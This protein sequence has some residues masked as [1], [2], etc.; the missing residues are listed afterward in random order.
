M[1]ANPH[2]VVITT[3]LKMIV[4]VERANHA[5]KRFNQRAFKIGFAVVC[6]Q[7]ILFH[8]LVGNNHMRG[9]AAHPREGVAGAVRAVREFQV[10]LNHIT[11]TRLEFVLP[12]FTHGQNIAAK[13]VADDDWVGRHIVGYFFMVFTQ[14]ASF[15]EERHRLS[16]TTVA[17]ISS[18]CIS[19]RSKVSRRKSRLP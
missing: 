11:L 1:R 2:R 10:G 3:F 6:Q 8:D 19:G 17:R 18:S 15:Q 13:L 14:V 16:V 4:G 12:L 9:F 7:A 5:G